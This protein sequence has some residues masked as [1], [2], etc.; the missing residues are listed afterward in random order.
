MNIINLSE[1]TKFEQFETFSA[2]IYADDG[3]I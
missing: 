3:R 2:L 1:S